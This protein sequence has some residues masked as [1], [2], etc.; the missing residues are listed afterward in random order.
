[1]SYAVKEIFATLQGE[2]AQAGRPSVFCRFAGCNLWS[3]REE[4][5]AGAVCQFCDTDFIGMDGEGGGRFADAGAL[6]AAIEASWPGG[7]VRPAT[8]TPRSAGTDSTATAA[9]TAGRS[10]PPPSAAPATSTPDSPTHRA[11]AVTSEIWKA[12]ELA[13]RS[14]SGDW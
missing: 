1:M 10:A 6:A 3:G 11:E 7:T 9:S 13:P 2:G 12:A 4:D 14:S 5:R 8:R